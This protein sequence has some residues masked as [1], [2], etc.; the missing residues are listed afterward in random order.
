MFKDLPWRKAVKLPLFFSAALVIMFVLEILLPQSLISSMSVHPR[1]LGHF[2][3]ILF[4]PLVHFSIPHLISNSLGVIV[5][6]SLISVYSSRYFL[7]VTAIGWLG[8]GILIW[9]IGS[10]QTVVGGASGIVYCYLG[11]LMAYGFIAKN[12]KSILLSVA[13]VFFFY[14]SLT[15]L[16][17]TQ[18]A[19]SWEGHIAGF[20]LGLGCAYWLGRRKQTKS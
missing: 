9:L 13:V 1:K 14:S 6:G 19:I 15:G 11:F 18:R 7:I 3:G 5:L 8:G 4:H 12:W 17:P 2:S 16:F 10:G 20:A